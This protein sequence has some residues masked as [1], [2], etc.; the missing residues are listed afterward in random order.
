MPTPGGS[1]D[2]DSEGGD[3]METE[4]PTDRR[5]RVEEVVDEGD[6]S[7]YV[8]EFPREREAGKVIGNVRDRPCDGHAIPPS[9]SATN[10][11]EPFA[12]Q[13]EWDFVQ[14]IKNEGVSDAAFDRYC[15]LSNVCSQ[16]NPYHSF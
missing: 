1:E 3:A 12:D 15:K 16:L 13:G 7:E 10:R 2:Q 5:A 9:Q 6:S 4:T 8:E 14:W 11:Y